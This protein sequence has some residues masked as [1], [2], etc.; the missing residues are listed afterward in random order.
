MRRWYFAEGGALSEDPPGS[1]AG[2]D[3]YEVD[4]EATTGTSNRWHTQD[5]VTPV[6][7]RDRAPADQLLLTYTSP[8]LAEDTEITGHATVSLW[9]ASTHEDGAFFAYLEDVDESGRVTYVTEGVLRA[10]HRK[11]SDARPPYPVL[12]PYHTYLREDAM[13]LVPGETVEVSF[14]L[15]PTSVLIAKGH[16]IRIAI[17]GADKDTFARIPAEGAPTLT[18]ERDAAHPSGVWLPVIERE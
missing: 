6:V 10:I 5:G 15:Q 9:V 16:R 18:I 14:G 8:P 3:T 11:T 7:Y 13:P 1:G 4:F 2:A 12:V 17:A